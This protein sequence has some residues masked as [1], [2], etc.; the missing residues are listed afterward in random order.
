M[1]RCHSLLVLAALAIPASGFVGPLHS[2]RASTSL[3]GHETTKKALPLPRAKDA[4][5]THNDWRK[6]RDR[7]RLIYYLQ[8]L[9]QSVVDKGLLRQVT[10]TTSIATLVVFF[11]AVVGG[12]TDFEGV[13]QDALIASSW[14]PL[15]GLPLV[16]FMLSSPSLA[17]LLGTYPTV[18]MNA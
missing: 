1:M 9:V 18:R 11:N 16:P 4:V 12:Y 13:Q 3:H 7:D 14:L 6:F 15:M 10:A 2:G 8:T 5:F 17:L